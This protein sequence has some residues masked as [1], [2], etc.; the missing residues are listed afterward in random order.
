MAWAPAVVGEVELVDGVM[1]H[2]I[3]TV[4]LSFKKALELIQVVGL[5]QVIS[6]V[7]G[8]RF[9]VGDLFDTSLDRVAN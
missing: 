5:V 8:F 2:G 4:P 3:R 7:G 6:G 1:G 9:V